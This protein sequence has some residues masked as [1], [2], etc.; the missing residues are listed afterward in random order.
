VQPV[1]R[2]HFSP[3]GQHPAVAVSANGQG[4][5]AWYEAG[6][7]LTA[8]ISKDGIGAVSRVA[9]ISGEQP[10]PSIAAGNKPGEWYLAW[11]D[12]ETGHLEPYAARVQCK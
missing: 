3:K 10:M 1:V 7:V 5:V 8:P 9:R 2:R 12:Y 11:L 4:Q 6:R